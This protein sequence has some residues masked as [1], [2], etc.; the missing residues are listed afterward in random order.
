MASRIGESL[1]SWEAALYLRDPRMIDRIGNTARLTL[2]LLSLASLGAIAGGAVLLMQDAKRR[3]AWMRMKS[4]FVSSVSHE[5]KT[6]LTSIRM[7]A[8]LLGREASPDSDKA[9]EF[10]RVIRIESERLSR[11]VDNVLDFDKLERGEKTVQLRTLDAR[12]VVERAWKSVEPSLSSEGFDA[13]WKAGE[14]NYTVE[15]DPDAITQILLNL[16]SN[17]EKY[18][19]DGR[20]VEL[21]SR[22]DGRHLVLEV[23]DRGHG[24]DGEARE[25]IFEPFVRTESE[26]AP[27]SGMGLYIARRLAEAQHGRL[28]HRARAGGGSVFRLTLPLSRSADHED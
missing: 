27:G 11:L 12:S 14:G 9:R 21:R 25:Q 28:E 18:G 24:V 10:A 16:L 3:V 5:L 8:E 23:A 6:P 1:P 20:E 19:A 2:I 26:D 22:V 7:F 4:D 17:A 13:R 15:G